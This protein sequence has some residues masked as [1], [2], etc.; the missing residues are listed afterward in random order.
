MQNEKRK[1]AE[2]VAELKKEIFR[3]EE[4]AEN[5][6]E[7]AL[8]LEEEKSQIA[9]ELKEL[10]YEI[11]SERRSHEVEVN[12][13]SRKI[14]NAE[15]CAKK[16]ESSLEQLNMD[17][18]QCKQDCEMKISNAEKKAELEKSSL[19]SE[20]Q[21]LSSDRSAL[22]SELV[23]MKQQSKIQ[24]Q[25]MIQKSSE[26]MSKLES[27]YSQQTNALKLKHDTAMQKLNM[28]IDALR[29]REESLQRRLD[30]CTK[31]LEE[32]TGQLHTRESAFQ[33]QIS[34]YEASEIQYQNEISHLSDKVSRL[35]GEVLQMMTAATMYRDQISSLKEKL[36]EDSE[37]E[38]SWATPLNSRSLSS[39]PESS[40]EII[41]KMK[42]QLGELQKVLESKS[43]LGAE[44]RNEVA[45][46]IN[47]ILA[48]TASLEAEVQRMRQKISLERLS[49]QELCSQ[50]DCALQILRTEKNKESKLIKTLAQRVS[51]D[52]SSDLTALQSHFTR[53]FTQYEVKLDELAIKLANIHRYTKER[54]N[55]NARE[56]DKILSELDQSHKEVL[57]FKHEIQRLQAELEKSHHRMDQLT[58][59]Q[60]FLE[61]LNQA[62]DAEV[63]DLK[64]QLDQFI[65]RDSRA[66]QHSTDKL[67]S[68]TIKV[69]ADSGQVISEQDESL[70]R[71]EHEEVLRGEIKQ[72]QQALT[73]SQLKI[74]DMNQRIIEKDGENNQVINSLCERVSE[75]ETKLE[76]ETCKVRKIF[77]F[78]LQ[79][80]Y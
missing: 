39:S 33:Q 53:S 78:V 71:G 11:E 65:R 59:S 77:T 19:N 76:Q 62:K 34:V 70:V 36:Q 25:Y 54:D 73:H 79:Y 26:A 18:M 35:Q 61:E 50:K 28:E 37:L 16:L 42:V 5:Q 32:H 44:E 4:F 52:V 63:H 40:T 69:D 15:N 13:L 68:H 7:H 60:H 24:K 31:E 14:D 47:K 41:T 74:E 3:L 30:C 43:S 21:Y 8:T 72:L 1:N 29:Q 58:E 22:Q 27:K 49:H 6:Q 64:S 57:S 45:S 51:K 20:L 12:I 56:L 80:N 38:I 66:D 2:I 75:L 48:S 9:D 67:S 46:D 10:R 23:Q 55:K 17:Y